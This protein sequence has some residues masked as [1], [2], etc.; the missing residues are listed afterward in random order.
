MSCLTYMVLI[1]HLQAVELPV[2]VCGI[3]AE[4]IK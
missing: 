3:V 4:A 2:A 1:Q